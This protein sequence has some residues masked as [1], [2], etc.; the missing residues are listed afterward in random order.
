M[1]NFLFHDS[2]ISEFKRLSKKIRNL[3]NA[4]EDF[5]RIAQVQFAP[6]SPKQIIAP[7]KL[8]R[9]QATNTWS[10]W[11]VEMAVK[12]IKPNLFPRVWFATKGGELLFLSIAVHNE[13]YS[14]N[15]V[16]QEAIN[17]LTDFF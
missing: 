12:N 10:L 13:N 3:E 9:I 6:L 5:K 7:A 17:R 8:H 16:T 11:K 2:F 1:I 4:L 14:D 15:T